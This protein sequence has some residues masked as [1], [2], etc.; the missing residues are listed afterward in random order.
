MLKELQKISGSILSA[1]NW[2]EYRLDR[3]KYP[4]GFEG[5]YHFVHTGGSTFIIP[6]KNE[7]LFIMTKQYRYLNQK[8]SIEFPGGGLKKGLSPIENANQELEEEAGYKGNLLKIGEFNPFNGVTDEI[9][10]VFH[11]TGLVSCKPKPE[12]SEEFEI[13]ELTKKEI[14]HKIQKGEIWDGMT[15]AAWSIYYFSMEKEKQ[16]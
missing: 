16:I 1:N 5:E 13:I 15:L 4:S 14:I 10:A 2:W 12:E 3:Y 7:N 6:E 9:C 8:I 11:A